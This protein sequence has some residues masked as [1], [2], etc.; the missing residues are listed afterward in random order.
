MSKLGSEGRKI[1]LRLRSV[2]LC[3]PR[4]KMK[5]RGNKIKETNSTR[6]IMWLK[7]L[8]LVVNFIGSGIDMFWVVLWGIFWKKKLTK[9]GELLPDRR[10]FFWRYQGHKEVQEKKNITF[11]SLPCLLAGACLSLSVTPTFISDLHWPSSIE[12]SQLRHLSLGNEQQ[13]H[14]QSF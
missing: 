7:E 10:A 13:L 8:K 14:P 5:R 12:Q 4:E 2:I 6:N 3:F 11:A 1:A 9:W